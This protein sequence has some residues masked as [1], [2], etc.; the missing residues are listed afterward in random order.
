MG[1]YDVDFMEWGTFAGATS[2]KRIVN[3]ICTGEAKTRK[4]E[5]TLSIASANI[6][7]RE[8]GRVTTIWEG[9]GP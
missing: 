2:E 1:L 3:A 6:S 5:G 7:E 4:L 9:R 8:L